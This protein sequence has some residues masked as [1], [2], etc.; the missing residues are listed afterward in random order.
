MLILCANKLINSEVSK[1]H[2]VM[3]K[4]RND[5]NIVVFNVFINMN[6][7]IRR[8]SVN[9]DHFVMFVVVKITRK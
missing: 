1:T 9:I 8:Y 7:N 4:Y 5:P 6:I 2:T 3:S